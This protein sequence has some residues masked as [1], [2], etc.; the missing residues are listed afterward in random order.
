M[1]D[2]KIAY[3]SDIGQSSVDL[4]SVSPIDRRRIA[5]FQNIYQQK[6]IELIPW[7]KGVN[8][9][10]IYVVNVQKQLNI[11]EYILRVEQRKTPVII[12]VIEDILTNEWASIQVENIDD[13]ELLSRTWR[14]KR[15]SLKGRIK[16]IRDYLA[17]IGIIST[18]NSRLL[19]AISM[20]DT[21]I[22]TSE[23]QASSL[24]HINPFCYGIADCI[25]QSDYLPLEL[26][27]FNKLTAGKEIKTNTSSIR[28]VWEGTAWG[29]QLLNIVRS[30]LEELAYK[31]SNIELVCVMPRLRP[32]PL[33]GLK[34]NVEILKKH[35]KLPATLYEW[36]Q[37][38]AGSMIR[39]CDISIAPMPVNNPFYQAK[40][41]SKPLV[42]MSLGLPVVASGISSYKELIRD[43][44]DGLI[45]ENEQDW[46]R[47]L[48][49]LINDVNFR[50]HLGKAGQLRAN[51]FHA[52]EIV[53]MK[54]SKIFHNAVMIWNTRKHI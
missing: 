20:A 8:C 34:D 13:I 29:M 25:P 38:T 14:N 48:D 36:N 51:E 50:I 54:Y 4:E 40:A 1:S 15:K 52:T 11:A 33:F 23:T 45:A 9:D 53:A 27:S 49:L 7:Y 32:T 2:F 19:L 10:L 39:T 47:H 12:G 17:N 18:Y 41:F 21:V 26:A 3:V 5:V 22:C 28:V 46:F 37:K 16:W 44:I 43:G 24:R 31:H 30:P 6:G 42:Y 35:F